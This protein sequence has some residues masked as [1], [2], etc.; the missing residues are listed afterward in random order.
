MIGNALGKGGILRYLIL[1]WMAGIWVQPINPIMPP[2]FWSKQICDF[3][4][5]FFDSEPTIL[6][7][8]G[9]GALP[10]FWWF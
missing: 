1:T 6:R 3:S 5:Q 8:P 4:N 9:L 7:C 2:V 10:I